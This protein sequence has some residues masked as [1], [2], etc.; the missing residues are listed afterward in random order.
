[1]EVQKSDEEVLLNF[2]GTDY[3]PEIKIE[4]R[5]LSELN[6]DSPKDNPMSD[7]DDPQQK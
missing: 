1:M 6:I 7:D 4:K 2:I 3:S 5:T